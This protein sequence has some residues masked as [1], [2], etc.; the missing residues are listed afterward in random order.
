MGFLETVESARGFLERNG[1][2][3][4][5]GLKREFGLDDEGVEELN[6]CRFTSEASA[7]RVPGRCRLDKG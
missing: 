7:G 2:I 4:I 1:R 3:S 6:R 5:R